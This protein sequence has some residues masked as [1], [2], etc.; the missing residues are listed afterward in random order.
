MM[1]VVLES[2]LIFFIDATFEQVLEINSI[3]VIKGHK[4]SN[5]DSYIEAEAKYC[6]CS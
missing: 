3:S 1:L 5:Q 4:Y 2:H 6:I